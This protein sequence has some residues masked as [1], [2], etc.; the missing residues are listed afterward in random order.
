[1]YI[2]LNAY[3][4]AIVLKRQDTKNVKNK[5]HKIKPEDEETKSP[6]TQIVNH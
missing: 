4:L 1:M 2:V 6:K 3:I 5:F